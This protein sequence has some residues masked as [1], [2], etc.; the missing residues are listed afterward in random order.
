METGARDVV[1]RTNSVMSASMNNRLIDLIEGW[2]ADHPDSEFV[3]NAR[4]CS[5]T[6]IGPPRDKG[7]IIFAAKTHIVSAAMY[8]GRILGEFGMIGGCG[9]PCKADLR[10]IC[11]FIGTR[12]ALFIGDMDPPDLMRFAWLRAS[13]HPRNV[14]F[15]GV[16]D[17]F[18]NAAKIA[19]I[20]TLWMPC[21][22]S[23]Q[24]AL[25][26]LKIVVPDLRK[27][28]GKNCAR[29]LEKEQKIEL[30]GLGSSK[31]NRVAIARLLNR[32]EHR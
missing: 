13:L 8:E 9:L 7:R 2:F 16:N 4:R 17:A 22:P 30:D 26:I 12:D 28:V 14:I 24:M 6:V 20:K 1:A 25:P 11:E 27:V 32:R 23:E 21:S 10:W 31:R 3:S 15:V 29:M 19:S 18:I 5:Y